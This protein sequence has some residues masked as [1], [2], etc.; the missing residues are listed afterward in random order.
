[1]V[2]EPA[3]GHHPAPDRSSG[4]QA[5]ALDISSGRRCESYDEGDGLPLE[6]PGWWLHGFGARHPGYSHVGGRG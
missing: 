4:R 2:W 1:M 3:R 5:F 6:V